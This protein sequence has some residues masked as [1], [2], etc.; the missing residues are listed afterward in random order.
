[1]VGNALAVS[2]GD[3]PLLKK[4]VTYNIAYKSMTYELCNVTMPFLCN[5]F[6]N[7]CYVTLLKK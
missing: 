3:P 5:S 4:N 7:I 2:L 6:Y 1:V